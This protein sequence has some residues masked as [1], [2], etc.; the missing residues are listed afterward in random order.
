MDVS[1]GA[2]HGLYWLSA[3]LATRRPLL[4][5]VDDAQW[6]DDASVRFLGVLARRLD[7]LPV[8]VLLAQRP[9]PELLAELVAD[10]ETDHLR[11]QP[12]SPAAVERFLQTCSP[13]P[14][15][16]RIRVGVPGRD[17]R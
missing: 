3:N 7:G 9:A 12:L 10:P 4:L 11:I 2:L 13:G 1:F 17:R 14:C 5:A 16:P 8:V 6:A 15:G